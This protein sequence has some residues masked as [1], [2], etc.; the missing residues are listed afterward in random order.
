MISGTMISETGYCYSWMGKPV[1]RETKI[2]QMSTAWREY[3]V[4]LATLADNKEHGLLKFKLDVL[5]KFLATKDETYV[6]IAHHLEVVEE[7]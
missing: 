7:W 3:H 2:K 6:S 1:P 5:R 4:A